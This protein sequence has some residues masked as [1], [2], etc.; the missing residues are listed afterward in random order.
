M[1]NYKNYTRKNSLRYK[2]FDYSSE[3]YYFVTICTHNKQQILSK[4]IKD[5]KNPHPIL[6]DIGKIVA[7][8]WDSIPTTYS[9]IRTEDFV[10]MPNHIHGIIV[11]GHNS[12]Q[13][14]NDIVKSL[15]SISTIRCRKKYGND[16]ILWHR[17]FYDEILE[18]EE[19]Y[20][21]TKWYINCNPRNWGTD[22]YRF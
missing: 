9:N 1:D 12:E 14:L 6:T 18:H 22:K 21:N 19:H 5:G 13:S 2:D 10:I 20:L 3:G 11:I 7:D 17:G 4:I 8:V 15:K 16:F